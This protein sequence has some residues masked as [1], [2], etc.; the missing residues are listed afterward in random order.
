[1]C[2][3][4]TLFNSKSE[5]LLKYSDY[6]IS[7]RGDIIGYYQ[8]ED[9]HFLARRL[10][11]IGNMKSPQP[12]VTENSVLVFNGE[13]YNFKSLAKMLKNIQFFNTKVKTLYLLLKITKKS[14]FLLLKN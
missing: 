1:M 2:V 13:I 11:R 6:F 5:Q 7:Y 14:F 10:S 4:I 8:I 9:N 3:F 12:L